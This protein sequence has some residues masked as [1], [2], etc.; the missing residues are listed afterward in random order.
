MSRSNVCFYTYG[1]FF[2]TNVWIA[3]ILTLILGG[4][5]FFSLARFHRYLENSNSRQKKHKLVK[6]IF[7]SKKIKNLFSYKKHI[8]RTPVNEFDEE[9]EVYVIIIVLYIPI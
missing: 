1:F 4:F 2:R 8:I 5:I 3:I 9:G 7:W 6:K